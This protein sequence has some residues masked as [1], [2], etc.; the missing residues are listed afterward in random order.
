[1][2][3]HLDDPTPPTPGEDFKSEVVRRGRRLRL[4]RRLATGGAVM[5][6]CSLLL[7]VGF[8]ASALGGLDDVERLQVAGTGAPADGMS[9]TFLVVGL[10]TAGGGGEE[11]DARTDTIMVA[12]VDTD[13]GSV[14]MLSI[15]RDLSVAHPD[16]G[17]STRINA[18][19][20]ESGLS[21][22]VD[23][24]ES[25]LGIP[26]DHVVRI[27]FE[28][29]ER[30]VDLVGGIEI[31][32]PAPI[33]DQRAGLRIDE[34]GC[35]R[36]DGEDALALARARMLE[37]RQDDS[38]IVDPRGD[39]GR[40]ERQQVLV[41]AALDSLVGARPGPITANELADWATDNLA[42][43]DGLGRDDLVRFAAVALDLDRG[44]VVRSSLAV[45]AATQPDG[46]EVLVPSAGAGKQLD[47]FV[48][49]TVQD[50]ERSGGLAGCAPR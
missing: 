18:V 41:L 30:L 2:F 3:Q 46:A 38:W 23:V 42:V 33:R 24:I 47:A 45:E 40:M 10:D 25:Q 11:T 31:E 39:L 12:R 44:Q 21:G 9:T 4:R 36:L 16:S 29:F 1:M 8:Y 35:V 26:I 7:V 6:T 43:D 13:T 32:V 14:A 19:A 34:T 50:S 49:G 48:D 15:P 37:V 22:L 17:E 20:S 28:G 5:A 27:D